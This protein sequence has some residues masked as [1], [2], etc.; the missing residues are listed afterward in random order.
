MNTYRLEP[1]DSGHADWRFSNEKDVVWACAANPRL[2]RALVA[3]RTRGE[4][5][6]AEPRASPW[7]REALAPHSRSQQCP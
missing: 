6:V 2:A 5:S 1:I 3:A 4:A 7:E